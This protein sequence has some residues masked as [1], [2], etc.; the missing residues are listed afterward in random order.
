MLD[1]DY[2]EAMLLKNKQLKRIAA[3]GEAD[4]CQ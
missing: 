1:Y 2:N 4:L 3:W